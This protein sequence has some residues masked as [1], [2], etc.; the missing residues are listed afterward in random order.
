MLYRVVIGDVQQVRAVLE[1]ELASY[2]V[3]ELGSL[4]I[5]EDGTPQRVIGTWAPGQWRS[6]VE[7]ESW[8]RARKAGVGENPRGRIAPRQVQAV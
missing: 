5:Y 1:L 2:I 7:V 6:I 3:S 8:E 4:V